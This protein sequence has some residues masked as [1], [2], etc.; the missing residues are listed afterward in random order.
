[1]MVTILRST[2]VNIC[3]AQRKATYTNHTWMSQLVPVFEV[4][5]GVTWHSLPFDIRCQ[6]QL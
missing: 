4:M 1:M 3:S 5:L 2:N 6:A